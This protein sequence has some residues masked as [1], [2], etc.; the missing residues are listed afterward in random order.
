MTAAFG[1]W[2]TK[3]VILHGTRAGIMDTR[4]WG[5]EALKSM[6]VCI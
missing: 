4:N 5:I 2:W 6:C 1:V 3:T